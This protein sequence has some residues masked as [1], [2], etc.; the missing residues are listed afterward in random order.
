MFSAVKN[1]S[2]TTLKKPQNLWVMGLEI[3]DQRGNSV[4]KFT[5]FQ[6]ALDF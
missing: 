2:Q 5:P 1:D 3:M 4:L 6:S